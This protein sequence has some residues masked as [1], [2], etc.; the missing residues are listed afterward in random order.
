VIGPADVLGQRPVH[1]QRL[2]VPAQ[3]DVGRL[4]VAV[5]HAARVGVIDGVADI[6]E[7]AE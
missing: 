3:D 4:D 5:N 2:A 7:A 6:E 1:Y